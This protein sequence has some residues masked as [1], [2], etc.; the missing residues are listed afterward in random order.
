H[1][2]IFMRRGAE[3]GMRGEAERWRAVITNRPR[4]ALGSLL[5]GVLVGGCGSP[6]K[7][8]VSDLR[9]PVLVMYPGAGH[10]R[11]D[12]AESL[13]SMSTQRVLMYKDV[14]LLI[15]SGLRIFQLADL[16][17]TK[18]GLSFMASGGNGRTRVSFVLTSTHDA[19]IAAVR[20]LVQRH[21]SAFQDGPDAD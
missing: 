12:D 2:S 3:K 9:F 18:G 8:V 19:G 14:P 13:S 20:A 16:K 7:P 1:G 5:A 6:P 21:C 10:E 15:D 17:S 4:L 11:F